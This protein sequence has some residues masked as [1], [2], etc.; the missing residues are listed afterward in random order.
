[1]NKLLDQGFCPICRTE[2]KITFDIDLKKENL[3]K[4]KIVKEQSNDE[5]Y[6]DDE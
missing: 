2:I 4:S 1:M 5:P 3:I 6:D